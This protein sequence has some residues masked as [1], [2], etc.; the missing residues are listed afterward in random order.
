MNNQKQTEHMVVLGMWVLIFFWVGVK[1]GDLRGDPLTYAVIAKKT[2][3]ENQWFNPMLMDEPYLNKPPLFFWITAFFFKVLGAS[4]YVAKLPSLIFST[5]DVCM[6]YILSLRWFKNSDVAFFTAFSFMST[7]WVV[8]DFASVRPE[9]LLVFGLLLGLFAVSLMLE[10]RKSGPYL[11]GLAF[12]LMMMTK[13]A[14][15]FFLLA[16]TFI[17][18]VS[19][20]KLGEW[21]RW[22]HFWA[23]LLLGTALPAAWIIYYEGRHPGYFYHML[24]AQTIERMT[25]GLDVHN[26]PLL[27]LK[28]VLFYY[29]PWLIFFFIGMGVM[30]QKKKEDPVWLTLMAFFPLALALQ[31]SAGK[32]SRYLVPLTPF[33]SMI[34]AW[35]VVHHI[36][37]HRYIKQIVYFLGPL[38]LVFFWVVPV[39]INPRVYHTVHLTAALQVKAP[40]FADTLGFLKGDSPERDAVPLVEWRHHGEPKDYVYTNYFYLPESRRVWGDAQLSDY[41]SNGREKIFLLAPTPF[42]GA[43]PMTDHIAWTKIC[44]D[45]TA[46][47]LLGEQRHP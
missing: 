37:L 5:L 21:L 17:F 22:P 32:M 42:L 33:I 12:A 35:G 9:S 3:L 4:Y 10:G 40:S 47:L 20:W 31:V 29:H 25:G 19:R 8:R 26:S 36:R 43:L 24:Y 28:E 14:M 44:A 41:V 46:T 7:R 15:A 6:L 18:A 38:L 45:D 2:A 1:A 30:W 13:F 16:P 39:K 34:A 23:G 27:Y 11:F